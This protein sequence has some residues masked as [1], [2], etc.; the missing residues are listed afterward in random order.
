MRIALVSEWLDPWRG[1]AETSTLQFLHG[2]MDSGAEVHVFTR[3]RPSPTPGLVV[4]TVSGAAMS[5]SRRSITFAQRVERRFMGNSFDI[6]HAISPCRYADVY[7][8]RGGTVAESIQRNIA[9][10]RTAVG[11]SGNTD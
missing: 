8:P 1:G 11:S 4:H 7:Q 3:S 5:R 10:R 2:L 6:V 9:L